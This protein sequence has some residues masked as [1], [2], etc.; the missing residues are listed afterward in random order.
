MTIRFLLDHICIED[1]FLFQIVRHG[2]LSQQRCLQADFCADPLSFGVGNIGWML[3]TGART[4][5]WAEDGAL[6][7]IVLL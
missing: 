4:K 5:L 1:S 7:F 3:A 6:N 2:V